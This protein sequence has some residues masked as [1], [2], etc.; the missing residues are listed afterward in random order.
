MS[1]LMLL[2]AG[3]SGGVESAQAPYGP[4]TIA[5]STETPITVPPGTWTVGTLLWGPSAPL[6][7]GEIELVWDGGSQLVIYAGGDAWEDELLGGDATGYAIPAGTSVGVINTG[8]AFT[9]WNGV[10]P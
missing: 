2:G 3:P 1:F 10:E 4:V 6:V 5:A 9:I 8:G 7:A